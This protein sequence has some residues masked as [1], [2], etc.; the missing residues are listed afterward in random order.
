MHTYRPVIA[1]SRTLV[2][3]LSHTDDESSA[4][5]RL[6]NPAH[7]RAREFRPVGPLRKG[8]SVCT[9]REQSSQI[10]P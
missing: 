1:R 7:H 10:A 3:L 2:V 4:G 5:E 9:V 6:G 8:G